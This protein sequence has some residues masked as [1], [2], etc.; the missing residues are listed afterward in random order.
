MR[1]RPTSPVWGR[2]LACAAH[3]VCSAPGHNPTPSGAAPRLPK[4]TPRPPLNTCPHAILII[5]LTYSVGIHAV[6]F[7]V[8]VGALHAP[9]LRHHPVVPAFLISHRPHQRSPRTRRAAKAS[10]CCSSSR[11]ATR[12]WVGPAQ[13]GKA[14]QRALPRRNHHPPPLRAWVLQGHR[15]QGMCPPFQIFRMECAGSGQA[16][17]GWGAKW[18]PRQHTG[19]RSV[20]ISEAPCRA[21]NAGSRRGGKQDGSRAGL[22]LWA[23]PVPP[24]SRSLTVAPGEPVHDIP[25]G[26]SVRGLAHSA[27]RPDGWPIPRLAGSSSAT[28]CATTTWCLTSTSRRSGR[29]M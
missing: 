20:Q 26:R 9:L 27:A 29:L 17:M 14:L 5:L 6:H 4:V 19:A 24:S 25:A 10:R 21:R 7:L 18:H 13:L 23:Q 16:C 3:K 11:N 1:C 22:T 12:S 2:G 15:S 28:W 8:G